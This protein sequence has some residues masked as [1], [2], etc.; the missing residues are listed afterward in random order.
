MKRSNVIIFNNGFTIIEML[1]FI[2]II[3]IFAGLLSVYVNVIFKNFQAKQLADQSIV[4]AKY[5]SDYINNN[6]NTISQS[7]SQDSSTIFS[8]D[9]VTGGKPVAI[10]KGFTKL[11]VFGQAPCISVTRNANG[12]LFPML[13]YV[14]ASSDKQVAQRASL[15]LGAKGGYKD[16]NKDNTYLIKSGG[17]W[18]ID[19]TTPYLKNKSTEIINKCKN[20]IAEY[21]VF[22]NLAMFPYFNHEAS[23]KDLYLSRESDVISKPGLYTNRN[24]LE[25]DIYLN[26]ESQGVESFNSIEFNLPGTNRGISIKT[27]VESNNEVLVRGG[28]FAANSL[29]SY[30]KK[31]IGDDCSKDELGKIYKRNLSFDENL[32]DGLSSTLICSYSPIMCTILNSKQDN[33]EY[34]YIPVKSST[35]QIINGP[36]EKNPFLCPWQLPIAVNAVVHSSLTDVNYS[37]CTRNNDDINS[38]ATCSS[39]GT[40]SIL[41][42]SFTEGKF[43]TIESYQVKLG[44]EIKIDSKIVCSEACNAWS[45]YA[46]KYNSYNNSWNCFCGNSNQG[47]LT[48]YIILRGYLPPSVKKMTCTN[49]LILNKKL[50]I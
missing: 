30:L 8:L 44:Y 16:R 19:D 13:F 14:G 40:K 37:T 25:T 6:E 39:Y 22:L 21:S 32:N 20:E 10:P 28:N 9:G 33:K 11:N 4:Y 41:L 3:G 26:S 27:N 34:C 18:E 47:A 24:T 17:G 31:S 42:P 29:R 2:A 46:S 35:S 50:N 1:L 23:I 45:M 38:A 49:R 43:F 15:I 12:K 5:F 7:I 36:N 48:N